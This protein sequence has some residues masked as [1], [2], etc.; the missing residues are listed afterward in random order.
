MPAIVVRDLVAWLAE[1]PYHGIVVAGATPPGLDRNIQG[2]ARPRRIIP[3]ELDTFDLHDVII[4][5]VDAFRSDAAISLS[6]FI[7]VIA[8]T[9]ATLIVAGLPARD[10]TDPQPYIIADRAAL[11]LI[12]V[13]ATTDL[14]ELT[15]AIIDLIR[16]YQVR[17]ARHV[18]EVRAALSQA[19]RSD[20]VLQSLATTLANETGL[21]FVLEDEHRVTV[22][23]VSPTNSTIDGPTVHAA[24]MSY[25]ARQAVRP[26][27][28][29]AMGEDI[30]IQRHLPHGLTRAIVPLRTGGTP[31]AYLSLLG[32]EGTVVP[33][34]VDLLWQIAPSFA[35]EMEKL[36]VQANDTRR[37]ATDDL[38]ALLVGSASE[39]EL[40]RRAQEHG[41][42]LASP[43]CVVV[44]LPLSPPAD[45]ARWVQER[46][47][48]LVPTIW[49][50]PHD[51]S[52]RFVLA[53]NT[54][55]DNAIERIINR[56][57]IDHDGGGIVV[58][59]G[60]AVIGSAA[61]RQSLH[62]AE[63]AAQVGVELTH[64]PITRYADLGILRLLYPLNASGA[65]DEFSNEQLAPLL[66][67]DTHGGD[68]LL[69]TLDTWFAVN[70]NMTE[71]ARRLS[72]HRNTLMY[73]I[74]RIQ[75]SLGATLDDGD[76]RLALQVALKIWHVRK[77]R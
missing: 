40:S 62:E 33:S 22:I 6:D 34:D 46:L 45:P 61:L 29:G 63:L 44:A 43:H 1:P 7:S 77:S 2:V 17:A 4:A 32:V 42:D 50:M 76:L 24:L 58:G 15:H 16:R 73:R 23:S 27:T 19:R 20:D 10:A 69:K 60:G 30:P 21:T 37:S 39:A 25:A 31:I 49:A 51:V 14:A 68:A 48:A 5:P 52:L 38:A 70:G 64:A 3:R 35:F 47:G 13:P 67:A 12:S 54:L 18:R 8:E 26:A 59:I 11:P 72:L 53:A 65:L 28:P 57:S 36:R 75:D 9:Q 66:N 74:N 71:A 55:R 56:L 41:I